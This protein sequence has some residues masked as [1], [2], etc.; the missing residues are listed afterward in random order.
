MDVKMKTRT[1]IIIGIFLMIFSI[2]GILFLESAIP[3]CRGFTGMGWFVFIAMAFN[4]MTILSNPD[5]LTSFY[6]E[7][8]SGV[9]FTIGFGLIIHLIVQRRNNVKERVE[10][11]WRI[12]K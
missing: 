4:P 10:S 12:R 11:I 3:E 8:I 1:L 6:V 9:L 5:C 7:T 2:D